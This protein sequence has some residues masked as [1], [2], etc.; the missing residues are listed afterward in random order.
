MD[1]LVDTLELG[2][3]I[4]GGNF[5]DLRVILGGLEVGGDVVDCGERAVRAAHAASLDVVVPLGVVAPPPEVPV[6]VALV[7]LVAFLLLLDD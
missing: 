7:E 6:L 1:F 3:L 4:G 2:L 5:G